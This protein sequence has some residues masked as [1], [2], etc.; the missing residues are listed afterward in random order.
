[1]VS[2]KARLMRAFMRN[3]HLMK[4]SMLQFRTES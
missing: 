3:R 1:M 4:G 2:F